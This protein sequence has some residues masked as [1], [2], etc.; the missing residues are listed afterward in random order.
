MTDELEPFE[1]E[2]DL[3]GPLEKELQYKKLIVYTFEKTYFKL[4]G[5]ERKEVAKIKRDL[6]NQKFESL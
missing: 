2:E 6:N 3:M 5:K 4:I 1:E